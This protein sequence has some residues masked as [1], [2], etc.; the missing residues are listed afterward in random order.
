MLT[1]GEVVR[2]FLITS[3]PSGPACTAQASLGK[4]TTGQSRTFP[5]LKP[6]P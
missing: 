5:S 4:Q 3:D 6:L 2:R 1:L